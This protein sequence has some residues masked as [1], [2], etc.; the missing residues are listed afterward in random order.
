MSGIRIVN[1][2]ETVVHLSESGLATFLSRRKSEWGN[3]KSSQADRIIGTVKALTNDDLHSDMWEMHSTGEELLFLLSGAVELFA[4]EAGGASPYQ[5][6]AGV[7]CI[8]GKN[9][10]HRLILKEPAEL[11]FV[12]PASGTHMRP[13]QDDQTA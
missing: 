3:I 2:S 8:V 12:T 7:F 1:A 13:Y 6:T 11:L 9:V 5:M 10:W 4:D